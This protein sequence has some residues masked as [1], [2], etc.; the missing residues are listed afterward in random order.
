MLDS[1]LSVIDRTIR[2]VERRAKNNRDL[3][4][5]HI[6]PLFDDLSTAH[7]DYR[8]MFDDLEDL[9]GRR[10]SMHTRVR[11]ELERRRRELEHV[12]E[13]VRAL[14]HVLQAKRDLPEVDQLF[15]RSVCRYFSMPS[16]HL[17]QVP[18]HPTTAGTSLLES[19]CCIE[20]SGRAVALT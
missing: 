20:F 14:A 4:Q 7:S 11:L 16:L 2:L 19:F 8:R 9:L 13:K 10:P 17:F 5:N 15:F 1:I 6:E 12:R 3:F 18:G